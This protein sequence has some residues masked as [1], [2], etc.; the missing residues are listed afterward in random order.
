MIGNLGVLATETGRHDDAR[1]FGEQALAIHRDLGNRAE[2]G[3]VLCNLAGLESD[4]RKAGRRAGD[5]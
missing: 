4:T 3:I 1:S 5:G 2:E